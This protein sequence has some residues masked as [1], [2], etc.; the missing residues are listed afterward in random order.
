M[1]HVVAATTNPA[2]IKAI[3]L[4][5]D[6]VY[7]PG[8]YRI[9]GINV[10]SGVPLQPI[11]SAETRTGARQRVRN[12]RQMRPEADFWVGVEAGIE[13][14]MTFAWIVIEH[15]QWR[16]ESRSASLMLPDI[17]LQ[18]IRQGRELGDEMADLTGISNVK[19]KG[20]AIGIF[21]DGK[22]TRTSVYH[23]ALLLALVPFNNE[24]YQRPAQ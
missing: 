24:I 23:Q 3:S 22:L 5:F 11:G 7:G 15:L 19:H 10:D 12:A 8:Q 16:G 4:A 21:T 13:D 1:Y 6:D 17:I 14:N 2:K 18:G 20:G 9:E